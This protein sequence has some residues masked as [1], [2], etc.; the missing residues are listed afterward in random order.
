MKPPI[1]PGQTLQVV[2]PLDEQVIALETTISSCDASAFGIVPPEREGLKVNVMET[3]LAVSM[4][5]PDALYSMS[6]PV[7][8]IRS[9]EV[10]LGIPEAKAIRRVQQREY[11]RTAVAMACSVEPW[12]H[13]MFK[14]AVSGQLRDLSGG[15]CSIFLEQ[16]LWKETLVKVFLELADIGG[17]FIGRVKHC[18][19]VETPKGQGYYVGLDFEVDELLRSRLI[20]FVYGRRAQERRW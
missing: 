20:R 17:F 19:A 10:M 6:C 18:I 11:A 5:T 14:T 7:L 2:V 13:G 12:R 3:T 4:R 1:Y 16:E 15:G 8:E 9:G